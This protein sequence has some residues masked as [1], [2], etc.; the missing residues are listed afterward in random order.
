MLFR[1]DNSTFL[2]LVFASDS[3]GNNINFV[4]V[5]QWNGTVY[6]LRHNITSTGGTYRIYNN[7]TTKFIVNIKFN[8]TLA[9]STAEAISFTKIYMNI[10]TGIWNNEELNNTDCTLIGN[11]YILNENGVWNTA[12]YPIGGTTYACAVLYEGYY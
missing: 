1:F 12:G 6:I 10:T 9:S 5:Y 2:K 8:S 4:A 7:Q 3:Y 11:Y